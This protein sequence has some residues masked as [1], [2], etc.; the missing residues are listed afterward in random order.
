MSD[1]QTLATDHDRW[2][3]QPSPADGALRNLDNAHAHTLGN[4]TET[5]ICT[6]IKAM[7]LK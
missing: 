5:K 2:T 1:I 7:T 6:G 4:N 3:N